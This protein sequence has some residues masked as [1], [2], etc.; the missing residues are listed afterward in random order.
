MKRILVV[1]GRGDDQKA[2]PNGKILQRRQLTANALALAGIEGKEA[3][4]RKFSIRGRG[5]GDVRNEGTDQ[6]VGLTQAN[7]QL[8]ADPS[9]R[10][11]RQ[12]ADRQSFDL[13]L[14]DG[15]RIQP[16]ML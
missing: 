15:F 8:A 3:R 7:H 16:F 6:V 12:L 10:T 1:L 14:I 11:S 5:Q 9:I 2:L 13:A 4:E